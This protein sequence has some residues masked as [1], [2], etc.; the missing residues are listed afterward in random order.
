M[1]YLRYLFLAVLGAAL[2]VVALANRQMV[3]LHLLPTELSG[4]L[5]FSWSLGL[6]LFIVIFASI[7]VG[8]LV[9]FVWE[10]LREYRIRSEA[11]AS[12]RERD[13][14]KREVETLKGPAPEK[15]DDILALLD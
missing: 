8:I 9:G 11:A 14:L 12:K 4:F 2:I 5:G 13:K 7:V 6:P 15:G 3:E 10:W 1:R